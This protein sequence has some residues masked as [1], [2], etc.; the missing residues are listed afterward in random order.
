MGRW[1]VTSRV[2]LRALFS[3]GI[4]SVPLEEP[5]R[6]KLSDTA[7]LCPAGMLSV[8]PTVQ[9][10]LWEGLHTSSA[11]A[12]SSQKCAEALRN[13]EDREE[14]QCCAGPTTPHQMKQSSGAGTEPWGHAR[15]PVAPHA[16]RKCN[17][18][19][20]RARLA[21][22]PHCPSPAFLAIVAT[23][24]SQHHPYGHRSARSQHPT[25]TAV[26]QHWD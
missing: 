15:P 8:Q 24:H 12:A 4:H 6:L 20:T 22:Q 3:L 18:I 13:P 26:L 9:N 7:A 21:G 19:S 2:P 11:A 1:G 25:G 16:G 23:A 5:Q 10:E 14:V 17:S